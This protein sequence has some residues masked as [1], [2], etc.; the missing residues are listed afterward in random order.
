ML[1]NTQQ[2][3]VLPLSMRRD[4][5]IFLENVILSRTIFR[6]SA[7]SDGWDEVSRETMLYLKM[8]DHQLPKP[9]KPGKRK[10]VLDSLLLV[11][12]PEEIAQN[13]M[14]SRTHHRKTLPVL[15]ACQEGLQEKSQTSFRHWN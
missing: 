15:I 10:I 6:A 1:R 5:Q 7:S 11:D 2:P 8:M 9:A 14:L 3:G 13:C 12:G 4:D